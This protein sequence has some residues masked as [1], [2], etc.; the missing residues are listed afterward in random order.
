MSETFVLV[1]GAWHGGW[2]WRPVANELRAAGH[3]VHTR[4]WPASA[5]TTTRAA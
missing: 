1:T 2:A 5:P 3:E 4:P